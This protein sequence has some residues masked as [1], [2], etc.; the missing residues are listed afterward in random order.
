MTDS[1]FI[2]YILIGCMFAGEFLIRMFV[3]SRTD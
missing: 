2:S 1:L 3:R